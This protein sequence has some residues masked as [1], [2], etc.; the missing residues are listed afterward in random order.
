M[1]KYTPDVKDVQ[2]QTK[3]F[4]YRKK[5]EQL[6]QSSCYF[7]HLSRRS[8]PSHISFN[9][10][11]RSSRRYELTGPIRQHQKHTVMVFVVL[12]TCFNIAE[13]IINREGLVTCAFDA[14]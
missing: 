13:P 3:N 6:D 4:E 7:T 2:R 11:F 12:C 1:I 10:K 14:A 5:Q 9:L 8:K